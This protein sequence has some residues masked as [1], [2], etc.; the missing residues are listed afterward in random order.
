MPCPSSAHRRCSR[1]TQRLT[2][3]SSSPLKGADPRR[4]SAVSSGFAR[5]RYRDSNPG[6]RTENPGTSCSDEHTGGCR[7]TCPGDV[8]R[9]GLTPGRVRTRG[10]CTYGCLRLIRT[11]WIVYT[12]RA[13]TR[14]RARRTSGAF[15][16]AGVGARTSLTHGSAVMPGHSPRRCEPPAAR[17]E[18]PAAAAAVAPDG[19]Y[20]DVTGDATPHI[21]AVVHLPAP[22]CHQRALCVLPRGVSPSA[23]LQSRPCRLDSAGGMEVRRGPCR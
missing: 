2:P 3:A 1:L 20:R 13:S 22:R 19:P 16:N 21:M 23:P 9:R 4:K 17:V 8:G 5:H 7:R 15:K 10:P 18:S 14:L 11:A 12:A 6:F